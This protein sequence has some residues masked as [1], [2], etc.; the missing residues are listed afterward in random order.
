MELILSVF[1]HKGRRKRHR[2]LQQTFDA[3]ILYSKNRRTDRH[4]FPTR[5][6]A[7][8]TGSGSFFG[9][10]HPSTTTMM[11]LFFFSLSLLALK[12]TTTLSRRRLQ[13]IENER[14]FFLENWNRIFPPRRLWLFWRRTSRENFFARLRSK[15][16][17]SLSVSSDATLTFF[18]L[19]RLRNTRV[20]FFENIVIDRSDW[21]SQGG[22]CDD[23]III[24]KV[25][26]TVDGAKR[27]RAHPRV[28]QRRHWYRSRH[29]E[30]VRRGH[31]R[32]KRESYRKR[33]RVKDDAVHGGV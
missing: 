10:T 11:M 7:R 26:G 17:F 22:E 12:T 3:D 23:D 33:G 19:L 20:V 5:P 14:S 2:N 4:A 9:G 32:Q 13:I 21:I 25:S 18:S 27:V 30:L 1:L 16:S 31:G 15:V 28:L 29:D 8:R 6:R 24:T